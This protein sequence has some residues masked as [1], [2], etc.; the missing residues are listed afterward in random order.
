MSQEGL[1]DTFVYL[2]NITV[3]GRDQAE[4]DENLQKLLKAAKKCSL[5]FNEDNCS[6]SV[7]SVDLLGYVI[8]H[9]TLRPDP[10]RLRPLQELPPPASLQRVLGMFAHYS[11]WIHGFSEKI[12]PLV[13]TTKIPLQKS[14]LEAFIS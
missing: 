4:H 6:Y 5:T 7:T 1:R 14:A 12:R 3:C 9:G 10:E 8:G 13:Q 11:H 2:D